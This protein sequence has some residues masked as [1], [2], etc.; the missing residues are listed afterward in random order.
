MSGQNNGGSGG[1]NPSTSTQSI[2]TT[3]AWPSMQA[4]P[5]SPSVPLQPGSNP[6]RV[7]PVP[8]NP[9]WNPV[10][11]PF[12]PMPPGLVVGPATPTYN[13][14]AAA[15]VD[16]HQDHS[17]T[18]SPTANLGKKQ[19]GNRRDFH[20]QTGNRSSRSFSAR[21]G[22]G[23]IHNQNLTGNTEGV[24]LH[25]RNSQYVNNQTDWNQYARR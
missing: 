2:S 25:Y 3:V 16:N 9:L 12:P 17:G 23:H 19:Q 11:S 8:T 20:Q 4:L 6:H 24:N 1:N 7:Y 21:N 14:N 13:V 15:R 5:V 22:R 10:P 18:N